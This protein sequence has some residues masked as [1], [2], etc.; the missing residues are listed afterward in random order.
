M[1]TQLGG[2]VKGEAFCLLRLCGDLTE[3]IRSGRTKK[4]YLYETE[5]LL[6]H[7]LESLAAVE[8]FVRKAIEEPPVDELI[9]SKLRDFGEIRKGLSWLYIL[10]KEAIDSDSLSIPFSL[11]I[12]LNHTAGE[13]LKPKKP[14]LVV[15]SGSN[16]MY[17][18]Y[19]LKAMRDLTRYLSARIEHYPVLG[20]D[21]GV[22]MFP[23]CAAREVLVNCNLFHEMGHYIYETTSLEQVFRNELVN[24]LGQFFSQEPIVTK[25]EAPLLAWRDLRNYVLSLML[26]WADEV[27][28]DIFAVRVLGPAFHLA[29]RE[30]EQIIPTTIAST[31]S[32][33]HPAD[34]YRFKVHAKWLKQD[35]WTE[36]LRDKLPDL[37]KELQKC[38]GYKIDHFSISCRAPSHF[39]SIEGELHKWM[40]KEFDGMVSRI[41]HDVSAKLPGGFDKPIT[42]FREKHELVRDYFEHAVVPSTLYDK[43]GQKHHPSP[44]T[45]LNSGFFFYLE[46]MDP[47]LEIVKTNLDPI[48]KQMAYEKRLNDWLAKAIEDWQILSKGG[49]L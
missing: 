36:I 42:D 22:L 33:T 5:G 17:Y 13:L 35:G 29:Y 16:L 20:E 43:Q 31:F 30:I 24:K 37:L 21:I 6:D 28:A 34:E 9:R 1:L 41:E 39:E 14:S 49:K 7:V 18:K 12:F 26:R 10:A 11:A 38:E 27:F 44:T 47:L 48:G 46:G 40:L 23:Y 45:L 25:V 32:D 19:N 8:T 3:F 4:T 15:L 2:K